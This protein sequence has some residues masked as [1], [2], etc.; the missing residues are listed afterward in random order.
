[1]QYNLLGLIHKREGYNSP[2][3]MYIILK[4]KSCPLFDE[5][6]TV[7]LHIKFSLGNPRPW[8]KMPSV[9]V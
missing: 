3:Y 5:V 2:A 1:M 4:Y 8:I 7:H 6:G 9:P